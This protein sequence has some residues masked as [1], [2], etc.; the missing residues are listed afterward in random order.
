MYQCAD[1]SCTGL[2]AFRTKFSKSFCF[3]WKSNCPAAAECIGKF[4]ADRTKPGPIRLVLRPLIHRRSLLHFSKD[5]RQPGCSMYDDIKRN[6]GF[7][8]VCCGGSTMSGFFILF[9]VKLW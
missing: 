4:D 8:T 5:S 2:G 7:S 9:I 3:C 6:C 1:T